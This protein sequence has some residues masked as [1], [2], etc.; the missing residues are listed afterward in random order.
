MIDG[1][2]ASREISLTVWWL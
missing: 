2:P 1:S